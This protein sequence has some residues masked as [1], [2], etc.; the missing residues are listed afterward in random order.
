[1]SP[2]E[3]LFQQ[4]PALPSMPKVVQSLIASLG[5]EDV[6]LG[7]LARDLK[8]DP[9]LSARVLRLANSGY[10][11]VG[12]TIAAIDDAV[13]L[14]GLNALRTLVIASGVQGSLAR[15]PGMNLN[16]FWTHALLTAEVARQLARPAG[17]PPE[18]A[19]SSGLM[20]RIGQVLI[21]MA[22]PE[23]IVRIERDWRRL[24]VAELCEEERMLLSFDHTEAGA[25][26]AEHWHF[27]AR[28]VTSLRQYVDPMQETADPC[29]GIVH[30][31]AQIAQGCE[32]GE[33][34]GII[35]DY[36]PE[37]LSERLA[38]DR[39]ALKAIIT[40]ASDLRYRVATLV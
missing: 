24:P 9:A 36:L 2:V 22:H 26:L 14:I 3:K 7:T 4:L 11:G 16:A 17:V 32:E 29:A 20:H 34:S 23:V 15:V 39:A 40:I 13:T 12:R 19:Y 28:I 30:I 8:Q 35:L 31:A 27:P 5:D 33:A 38:L 1:M 21:A 10:Y 37:E 25:A 6:D 18:L